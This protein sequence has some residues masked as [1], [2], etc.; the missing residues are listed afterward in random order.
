MKESQLAALE[1]PAYVAKFAPLAGPGARSVAAKATDLSQ[2]E[3]SMLTAAFAGN[4]RVLA[5]SIGLGGAAGARE[6][7]D[8]FHPH[9]ARALAIFGEED[10]LGS[11]HVQALL[12]FALIAEAM[13]VQRP[14]AF[15]SALLKPLV[16]LRKEFG[17]SQKRSIAWT[18]LAL[19]DTATALAMLN[20]KP[21]AVAAPELR[22]EFNQ[23]ALIRYV[24]AIVTANRPADWLESVWLEYFALF[25][26]HLAA[27][28]AYW[29]DLFNF[30]RVLATLRGEAVAAL[31]DDVHARV[32][33]A[34]RA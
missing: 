4:D 17:D 16:S 9:L 13:G 22:F 3:G 30:A 25:P 27:R 20:Q 31:A 10:R 24:A 34:A 33:L 5:A 29:P 19:G 21:R 18:A 12:N 6:M 28:A 15:D 26:M 7:V 14:P 8:R 32:M 11:V 2:R 23:L 1:W